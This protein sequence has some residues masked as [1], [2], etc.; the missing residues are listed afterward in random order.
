MFTRM[1]SSMCDVQEIPSNSHSDQK[2]VFRL[3]L[4]EV[5]ALRKAIHAA[6]VAID[7]GVE[8]PGKAKAILSEAVK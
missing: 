6:L 4:K 2:L 5:R 7:C 8:G 3:T 1:E